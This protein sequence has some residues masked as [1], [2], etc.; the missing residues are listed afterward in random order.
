MLP[1]LVM[2]AFALPT[3][4][5]L[6]QEPVV[7]AVMFWMDGCPHCHEVIDGTLASLEQQYGDRLNVRLVEVVTMDDFDHLLVIASRYGISS[8]EV[9]IP[10]LIIEDRVLLGS[11]EIGQSLP[12]LVERYLAEGGTNFPCL[13]EVDAG[14]VPQENCIAPGSTRTA[15]QAVSAAQPQPNGFTLAYAMLG[16]MVLALIVTIAALVRQRDAVPDIPAWQRWAFP[17]LAVVGLGVA[18]Y[19]AYVET[20]AVSAVCGPVGDCNTVQ[21]SPYAR[22]FG[23][24]VGV[25]GV[26]G[27]LAMLGA[28]LWSQIGQDDLADWMPLALFGMTLVG[29]LFSLYLTYLEPFVIGAVCAWCLSSAAIMTLLMLLNI[30]PTVHA[31]HESAA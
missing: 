14:L 20:Q 27:Y 18:G 25:L 11:H 4:P 10:F 16:G 24:P 31:L 30:R 12:W 1:L 23:I 15:E 7:Q 19:L 29:V 17:V 21:S 5:L 13:P 9:G 6:A 8:E 28:W 26:V 2:F 22:L 3:Q